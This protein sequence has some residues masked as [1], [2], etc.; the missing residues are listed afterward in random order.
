MSYSCLAVGEPLR[1]QA[2]VLAEPEQPGA[3]NFKVVWEQPVPP[4]EEPSPA[5]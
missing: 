5:P 3:E 2:V 4:Q 1:V